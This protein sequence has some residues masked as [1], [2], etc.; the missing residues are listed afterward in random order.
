MIYIMMDFRRA[1]KMPAEHKEIFDAIKSGDTEGA[2][3]APMC[4]STD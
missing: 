3:A 4:I 2:R 1:E